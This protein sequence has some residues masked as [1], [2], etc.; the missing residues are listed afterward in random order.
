MSA[1]PRPAQ[2]EEY[3]GKF[4]RN[5]LEL[6]AE[7][8]GLDYELAERSFAHFFRAAWPVLEPSTPLLPNWHQDLVAEYLQATLTGEIR[9]LII[10]MPPR[11]SKSLEI[12]VMFPAWCWIK[13]AA[14]RFIGASYSEDLATKHNI[15]RR[16]LIQSAWYQ[17]AWGNRFS[18][19]ADQNQKTE[20]TNTARGHCVG[21]GMLGTVTG[22]GGDYVLVDDPHNPKKAESDLERESTINA[23][24]STFTTRLDNKKTGRMIVVMQRLHHKDLTGHLL[25]KRAEGENWTHLN[26]P[27]EAP[28]KTVVRFPIS[29][30]RLVRE[31][32]EILHPQ[33]EGKA[34]LAAAKVSLGSYNYAGQYDQNPTPRAGGIFKKHFWRYYT[35]RPEKFDEQIQSWDL[36]F[37]DLTTSDFVVGFA[38]G[39]IGADVYVLD[40]I[41]AQMGLKASIGAVGTMS[42]RWPLTMLKLVEDKANGPALVDMLKSKISG[43]VL[44]NPEGSKLE[45]AALVEP[46]CEAG[47]VHWPHPDTH[48]W[49]KQAIAELAAFPKGDHDDVVDALTQGLKRLQ[50]KSLDRFKALGLT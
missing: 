13:N 50:V 48:P 43:L 18:F 32:G 42:T 5:P 2:I 15:D 47:N 17:A 4:G 14:L 40:M 1:P 41:R 33:R 49:V 6:L 36:A 38:L 22:K 30:K 27:A 23:F 31:K 46:M 44:E 21:V 45:R 7:L 12:T 25:A 34:E 35:A 19:S 29:G 3:C 8:S 37:K 39:R 24:D 10:N 11:Y 28:K 16:A 26:L 20:Y 9:R